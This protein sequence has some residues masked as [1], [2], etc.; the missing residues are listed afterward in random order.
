MKR[1][2]IVVEKSKN[3]YA[4][5]SPDVPG[6]VAAGE[7]RRE[8]KKLMKEALELH[9]SGLKEEGLKIPKPVSEADYLEV[10]A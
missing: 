5:F 10:A 2:L 3:G 8:V 6:C 7:T 1:Y 4:A 9:F